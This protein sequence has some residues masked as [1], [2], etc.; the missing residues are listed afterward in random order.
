MDRFAKTKTVRIGD[1]QLSIFDFEKKG[2]LFPVHKHTLPDNNHISIVAR[3]EIEVLGNPDFK[4]RILQTGA[5]VD[6]PLNKEHGFQ[7]NVDNTRLIN[8]PR[9]NKDWTRP[10][11][12]PYTDD[13]QNPEKITP[14]G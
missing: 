4:G 7:A 9:L 8:I 12:G 3:G 2:D 6:W 1:L 14:E 10:D 11:P 5:I 13:I